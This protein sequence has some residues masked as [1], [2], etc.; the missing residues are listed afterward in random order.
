MVAAPFP[1]AQRFT[2]T[3]IL[4]FVSLRTSLFHH[5]ETLRMTIMS[6]RLDLFVQPDFFCQHIIVSTYND[7]FHN[8]P[9][10]EENAGH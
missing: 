9:A 3:E 1:R 7:G 2:E 8:P 5:G 10:Q 4:Y 6:A